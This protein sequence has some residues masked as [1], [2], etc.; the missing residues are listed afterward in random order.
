[1]ACRVLLHHGASLWLR[2]GDVSTH[3]GEVPVVF[4]ARF[5]DMGILFDLIARSAKRKSAGLWTS[6]IVPQ[7]LEAAMSSTHMFSTAQLC[8]L[9]SQLARHLEP[10]TVRDGLTSFSVL[11]LAC[12][13]GCAAGVRAVSGRCAKKECMRARPC[14]LNMRRCCLGPACN[15]YAAPA[16]VT[17]T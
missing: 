3:P 15:S 10:A 5:E 13:H 9:I 4:A 12:K 11:M 1:M 6:A 7:I 16:V 17:A 2:A 14:M 8:Q